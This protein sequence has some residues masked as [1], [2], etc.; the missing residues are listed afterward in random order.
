MHWRGL[1]RAMI[2]TVSMAAVADV[3]MS[4]YLESLADFPGIEHSEYN[5]KVWC[6]NCNH[7][8]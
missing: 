2:H 3:M 5:I 8:T 6:F 4:L 7:Y 1:D